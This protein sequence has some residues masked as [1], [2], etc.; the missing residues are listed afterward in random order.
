MP[1]LDSETVPSPLVPL[2]VVPAGFVYP[3]AGVCHIAREAHRQIVAVVIDADAALFKGDPF[4]PVL[5]VLDRH[6]A[7][8]EVDKRRGDIGPAEAPALLIAVSPAPRRFRKGCKSG[9]RC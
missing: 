2:G 5:T 8:V 6:Q 3:Q 9:L 1:G 4:R 7:T